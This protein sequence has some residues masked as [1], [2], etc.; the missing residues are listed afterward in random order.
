MITPDPAA[1]GSRLAATVPFAGDRPTFGRAF[2]DALAVGPARPFAS[3]Y[4]T[5][6]VTCLRTAASPR[7][8][9]S[10][11]STGA[12]A[13]AVSLPT[14]AA[15]SASVRKN[16]LI[17]LSSTDQK[18]RAIG[19]TTIATRS[20]AGSVTGC[21]KQLTWVARGRAISTNDSGQ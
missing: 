8:T 13:T 21:M 17:P 12:P 10:V 11:V 5:A 7:L 18:T 1:S 9:S 14:N 19:V 15:T 20:S 4:V 6:G 2:D 16:R 3:I